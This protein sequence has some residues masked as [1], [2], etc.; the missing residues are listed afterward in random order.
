MAQKETLDLGSRLQLKK[1]RRSIE[2]V[3]PPSRLRAA[4]PGARRQARTAI[5]RHE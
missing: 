1:Y 5:R 4:G 2:G 3:F